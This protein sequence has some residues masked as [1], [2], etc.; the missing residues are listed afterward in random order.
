MNKAAMAVT[1]GVLCVFLHG[2]KVTGTTDY[3]PCHQGNPNL[4]THLIINR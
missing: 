3:W 1:I 2:G 4:N